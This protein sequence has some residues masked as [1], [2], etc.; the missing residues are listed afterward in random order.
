[1][2]SLEQGSQ[3]TAEGTGNA[4]SNMGQVNVNAQASASSIGVAAANAAALAANLERAAAAQAA[5]AATGGGS[6]PQTVQNPFQAAGGLIRG[7]DRQ[8]ASLADGE[9]VISARNTRRWFSELNAM[10]QGSAPVFREQGGS[11]TNVGDV[12]VTVQGGD[13]SQQTVREIATQLRREIKR[14]NIRLR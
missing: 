6:G 13:T 2:Q 5:V 3:R 4:A 10:N 9:S 8:A 12:N 14:G 7:Q 11:V 1:M